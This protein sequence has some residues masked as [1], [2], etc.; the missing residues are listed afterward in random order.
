MVTREE[1]GGI[2]VRE[3]WKM[4]D[5]ERGE[6]R[7]GREREEEEGRPSLHLLLLLLHKLLHTLKIF[8]GAIHLLLLLIF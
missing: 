5:A 8:Q 6:E 3:E 2:R 1:R 4:K 7:R